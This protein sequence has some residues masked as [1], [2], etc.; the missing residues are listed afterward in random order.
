VVGAGALLLVLLALTFK[1][2]SQLTT[3]P[4]IRFL[5]EVSYSFYLLH[6]PILL[7]VSSALYPKYQSVALCSAIALAIT[8]GVSKLAFNCIEHPMQ[9]YG[10]VV[11]GKIS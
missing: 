1:P 7:A 10:R 6:L 11:A 5:G 9:R 8:L 2:L 4:P 3:F